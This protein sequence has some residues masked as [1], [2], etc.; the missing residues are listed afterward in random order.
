MGYYHEDM[1]ADMTEECFN[2]MLPFIPGGSVIV[3]DNSK[4]H[5]LQTEQFLTTAWKKN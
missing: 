2:Q 1:N 4:Y 5:S 3:I